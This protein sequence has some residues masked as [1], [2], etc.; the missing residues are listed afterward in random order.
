M[1]LEERRDAWITKGTWWSFPARNTYDRATAMLPSLMAER[2]D[3]M[4]I[5][6]MLT[7]PTEGLLL[8]TTREDDLR[9][10]VC[11]AYNTYLADQ[12]APYADRMC[13]VAIIPMETP[14]EAIAELDYAVGELGYK[15]A[16]FQQDA[17]RTIPKIVREMPEA[18]PFLQR[19][20]FFGV[21]SA[22]DYDPVWQHCLDLGVAVTLHGVGT[23]RLAGGS[24]SISNHLA[25]RGVGGGHRGSCASIF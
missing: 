25:A 14:D 3:E 6:Y 22:Y 11:R 18:A 5:D 15:T 8:L 20:D 4:G 23:A 24:G 16:V 13:P 7:Y 19:P 1:P 17:A 9:Q 21:D 10:A 2:M 12:L